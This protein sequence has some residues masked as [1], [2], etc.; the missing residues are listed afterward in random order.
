MRRSLEAVDTRRLPV[1][2]HVGR[3]PGVDDRGHV[4]ELGRNRFAGRGPD[5]L[6]H[7]CMCRLYLGR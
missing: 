1:A 7:A 6:A 3:L 4:V 2:Q 5:L